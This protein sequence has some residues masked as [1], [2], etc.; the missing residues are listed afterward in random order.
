MVFT[1]LLMHGRS[2]LLHHCHWI[3]GR[4][5]PPDGPI[6]SEILGPAGTKLVVA[7]ALIAQAC[8]LLQ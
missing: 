2:D 1:R 8:R 7:A 3:D 4:D 5:K 6:A